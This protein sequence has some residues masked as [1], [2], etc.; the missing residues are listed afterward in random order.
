MINIA[1]LLKDAPKGMK[2]YS[3]LFGEVRLVCVNCDNNILVETEMHDN[4]YFA[5]NGVFRMSECYPNSECLLFPNKD[6]RSWDGWKVDTCKFKVLDWIVRNN[7]SSDVPIQVYGLKKDRYLVT[8]MLGTKGE[9]MITNQ[10]KWRFWTIEDAKDGDVLTAHEVIVLFKEID[11]LNIRCHFSYHYMN[12]PMVF[13]NQLHNKMAFR[14]ATKDERELLFAK[15]KEEGYEWDAEKGEPKKTKP[16]YDISNFKA[17]MPVL[18]RNG[19]CL[20]WEYVT[21]SHY[22]KV[23]TPFCAGGQYWYQCIPFN[24][25]T[26]HL[27]GISDPCDEKYINW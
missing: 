19:N 12:T 17:G 2:L 9:F 16:N 18:V 1:R 6:C 10:G 22:R 3:P 7:G 4:H 23:G 8:N 21:F 14:P 20:E 13:T 25:E 15:M 11:G 24:E 26:K 5:Y 27:L